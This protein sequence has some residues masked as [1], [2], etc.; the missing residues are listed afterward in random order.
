MRSRGSGY[1]PSI[2]RPP[3]PHWKGKHTGTLAREK[4]LRTEPG[5]VPFHQSSTRS[6]STFLNRFVVLPLVVVVF[7]QAFSKASSSYLARVVRSG[8]TVGEQLTLWW[9][10]E[11]RSRSSGVRRIAPCITPVRV[12]RQDLSISDRPAFSVSPGSRSRL[13]CAVRRAGILSGRVAAHDIHVPV[14]PCPGIAASDHLVTFPFVSRAAD[15][16]MQEQHAGRDAAIS[17]G[18]QGLQTFFSPSRCPISKW[19]CWTR[20]AGHR[21]GD[22]R[23]GA[24]SV[25]SRAYPRRDQHHAAV[26]GRDFSTNEYQIRGVVC[27]CVAAGDAGLITLI[28]KTVLERRPGRGQ[29]QRTIQVDRLKSNT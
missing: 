29:I 13:S 18:C 28:A 24:V 5:P 20:L 17:A 3:S 15:P 12:F 1:A 21:A 19:A 2:E 4:N 16:L 8:S 27:D 7:A 6:R 22:G 10:G 14:L 26:F 9:C 23:F 25:V 11:C